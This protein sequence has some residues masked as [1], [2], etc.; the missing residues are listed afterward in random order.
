MFIIPYT[1][2]LKLSHHI[3]RT[4]LKWVIQKINQGIGRTSGSILLTTGIT[5]YKIYNIIETLNIGIRNVK[6]KNFLFSD[7]IK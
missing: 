5:N 4:Y 6:N 3:N 2:N 7:K 1:T